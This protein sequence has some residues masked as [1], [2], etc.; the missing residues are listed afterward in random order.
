MDE[1]LRA[2]LEARRAAGLYRRPRR[3]RRIDGA[4]AEV[5]GRRV[6]VFCSNDYLG[7]AG[8]SRVAAA[9]AEAARRHGA[10]S[11]AAHLVSGHAEPHEALEQDLAAYLGRERA[12]LFSTGYMANLG[13][14]DALGRRGDPVYQDRLNHASLLDGARLAG[15]RLER[16][17]HGDLEDLER[18][19]AR[20]GGDGRLV[21]TDG[22]FSMD[23]DV[24]PLA[25]LAAATRR[26]G[27]RLMVDDAH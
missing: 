2:D 8:D 11:G 26:H 21:V 16:Y 9:L 13:V 6:V 4:E 12:L 1:A 27:A 14:I 18:R 22:V 10:G 7:L 25:G 5:D 23:G 15:A 19:M 17:R 20:R 24:A 3:V